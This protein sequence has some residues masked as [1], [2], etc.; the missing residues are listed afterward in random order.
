MKQTFRTFLRWLASI[1]ASLSLFIGCAH[2]EPQPPSEAAIKDAPAAA[3]GINAF[4]CDLYGHLCAKPGNLFFSPYSL[5]TAL[6][7]TY[8][9]ARGQTEAQ[10]AKTL[11]FMLTPDRLHPAYHALAYGLAQSG[12]KKGCVLSI[13]NALWLENTYALQPSYTELVKQN[14]GFGEDLVRK[15]NFAEQSE[16]ARL[17]INRW[18]LQ[19]TRDKIAD[20][21]APDV[22][23][24]ETVLILT[25]AIH[26]KG[27]WMTQ[28]DKDR[29]QDLPFKLDGGETI[30]APTMRVTVEAPYSED[31][32]VQVLQ[33]PYKGGDLAMVILLPKAAGGLDAFERTL[34]GATLDKRLATLSAPMKVDVFLPK[35]RMTSEFVLNKTLPAMGMT[36]AFNSS[37][38]DFSGM[39][40]R[41]D[42]FISNVIHKAFVD[43][44]E[45]GTEA[46]AAS[47][48][49]MDRGM[50]APP[51]V[52]RADHPFLFLIR[53]T[54]SGALLFLGRV[55]NPKA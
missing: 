17:I 1:S 3:R 9:G 34:D 38:A 35:F 39:A 24:R 31:E 33:L 13:A 41:K 40:G 18:V 19:Q 37:A 25:N 55:S 36:D 47:A 5:S 8:A 21:L 26:F 46:A 28:F 44:N 42:L 23:G 32:A 15:A 52:F 53:D 7:M 50:P 2:A 14:Y 45:E 29:T 30:P 22:V 43:V 11:R 27:A 54:R 51:A 49:V 6:A 16:Q 10:M 20:L 12:D 4:A 48:V